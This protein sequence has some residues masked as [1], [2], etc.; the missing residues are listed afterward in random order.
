MQDHLAKKILA[1][2]DK[3]VVVDGGA[4]NGPKELWGLDEFC[5][6]FCFEPNPKE[7]HGVDWRV[8]DRLVALEHCGPVVYPFA[9]SGSSGHATLKVSLRPGATSLLEPNREFLDRFRVDNFSELKEVVN[10][11]EVPTV[12]LKEFMT[13]AGLGHIDFLK[14]DTQGNE[15][16]IMRSAEE[17]LESIS[18]I[19]TEVEMVPLYQDQPLFHDVSSYLHSRG[20]EL[21]DFRFD[22]TCRRFHSRPDL[23]PS[24]YRL[25]WG[26]AIYAYKPYDVRKRRALEQGLILSGLGYADVAIDIFDRHPDVT[27]SLSASLEKFARAA[28]EP[29]SLLGRA[30]RYLERTFGLVMHRYSWRRGHQVNSMKSSGRR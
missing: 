9:L 27:S 11:I 10:R 16:D 25:V 29:H 30:K 21:I 17:Y 12:T 28:A 18:V 22:P 8:S 13:R 23:P 3:L 24:S 26:D 6:F 4:R 19:M 2:G 15:L 1:P 7:L 20:F 5:R 14:L